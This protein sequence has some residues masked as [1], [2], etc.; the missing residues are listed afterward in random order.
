ME[1][2]GEI[3]FNHVF[4]NRESL[5]KKMT[6]QKKQEIEAWVEKYVQA[7]QVVKYTLRNY[8]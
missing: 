1:N 3:C 7:M 8:E 4:Q 2:I 6:S 5:G